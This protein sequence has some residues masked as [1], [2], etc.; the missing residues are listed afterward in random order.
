MARTP[1]SQNIKPSK[2]AVAGYY[3]QLATAA[4]AGDSVAA[5]LLLLNHT[6]DRHL[7]AEQNEPDESQNS[8]DVRDYVAM[9]ANLAAYVPRDQ[10]QRFPAAAA[11]LASA[12]TE[13]VSELIQ[14][15][16]TA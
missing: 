3:K 8:G 14:E 2:Q 4:Y 11:E 6:M 12:M 10:W 5:G 13:K 7:N 1:G 16:G 15:D 9:A